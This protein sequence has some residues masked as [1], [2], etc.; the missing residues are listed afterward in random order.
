MSSNYFQKIF[1]NCDRNN[2]GTLCKAEFQECFKYLGLKWTSELD[3]KFNEFDDNNDGEV[4]Y[5]G[6][7]LN[8]N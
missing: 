2:S 8:S 6:K 7:I 5:E 1:K 3:M 4:A